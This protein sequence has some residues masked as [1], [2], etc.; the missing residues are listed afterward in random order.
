[1]EKFTMP[2]LSRIGKQ[3][4]ITRVDCISDGVRNFLCSLVL[5]ERN[6]AWGVI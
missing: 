5:L 3:N 1:M 6:G 2:H 4:V